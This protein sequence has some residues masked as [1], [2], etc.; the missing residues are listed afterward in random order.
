M[1]IAAGWEGRSEA[2]SLRQQA[3]VLLE[4]LIVDG[5]LVPSQ[6][7]TQK[8]LSDRVGLGLMPIREALLRLEDYGIVEIVPRRGFLVRELDTR[9]QLLVMEVRRELERTLV[10]RAARR[11]EP[12]ERRAL[13]EL[14]AEHVAAAAEGNRKEVLRCDRELKERLIAAA[15]N[16]YLAKAIAPIHALSRRFFFHHE[17]ATNVEVAQAC[18]SVALAV[19]RG[20]EEA[21]GAASDRLCDLIESVVRR[22]LERELKLL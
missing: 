4:E 14:A 1:T 12:G 10:T 13:R 9:G 16:G 17:Q 6:F 22:A 7:L 11:S 19:S 21:A 8:Q 18:A 20:S 15:R 2:R 3:Y 5:E